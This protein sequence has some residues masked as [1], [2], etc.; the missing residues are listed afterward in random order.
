MRAQQLT[1]AYRLNGVPAFAVNGKF[2]TSAYLTGGNPSL[3]KT[4]DELIAK[5]LKKYDKK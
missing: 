4:L 1:N 2:V 3:F 5:E